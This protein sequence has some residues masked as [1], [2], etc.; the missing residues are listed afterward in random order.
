MLLTMRGMPQI[1][2]GDEI[3]MQG[4]DDP[5]NRRNFPGGFP[6]AGQ[7]AFVA[8]ER[9]PAQRDMHDWVQRLLQL[10]AEYSELNSGD[11]RVLFADDDTLVYVRGTNLNVGCAAGQGRMLVAVNKGAAASTVPVAAKDALSGCTAQA[12]SV[13]QAVFAGNGQL[14]VPPGAA[15]LYWK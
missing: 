15:L 12:P 5:D 11:E 10:R 13:G 14:T 8:A 4:G 2:S 6:G 1:Y 9:T 3:A 7:S